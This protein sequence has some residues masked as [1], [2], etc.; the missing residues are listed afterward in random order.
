MTTA[1]HARPATP[2]RIVTLDNAKSYATEANLRAALTRTGLDQWDLAESIVIT[3][4]ADARWTAIFI[5]DRSQDGYIAA[6]SALGFYS[7]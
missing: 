7:F 2:P 1:A 6:A 5:L 4:T 3:R